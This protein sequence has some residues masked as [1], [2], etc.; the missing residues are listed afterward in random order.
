MLLE[1]SET[2]SMIIFLPCLRTLGLLRGATASL[3]APHSHYRLFLSRDSS[4]P[5]S[6]DIEGIEAS[7]TSRLQGWGI[8]N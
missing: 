6:R 2:S 1:N 4:C 5:D 3:A 7:Q 8:E